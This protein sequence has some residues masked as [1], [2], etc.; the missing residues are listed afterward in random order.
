MNSLSVFNFENNQVRVIT[1]NNEPWF[2]VKDLCKVL[3]ISK[4]RD[5]ISR[6]D[7][8]E[9]GSVKLDTLGGKQ[10]LNIVSESGM[11]ALVL[12]SRKQ[13]AKPFRKWITSEVLPAIRKTG[14]YKLDTKQIDKSEEWLIE[15]QESKEVRRT[16][17]DSIRD[18]IVRHPEMSA[19]KAKF[20]YS[21]ASEA[22][23]LGLFA[24]KSKALKQSIGITPSAPLREYLHTSEVICLKTV[25]Y[26]ACQYI[27]SRD[28]YPCDAVKQAIEM[29]LSMKK[30]AARFNE[31][32]LA[33]KQSVKALQIN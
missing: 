17:T 21:N 9:R 12:T 13:E 14:Q 29:S 25:E 31:I 32:Q 24:K 23:N 8:D 3:G 7:E 15:R 33:D 6:L 20:L 10:N 22:L 2:V 18:Y 28:T 26:L 16:L 4:Q 11:Y 5:A 1:K 30:F 19:N 27:D